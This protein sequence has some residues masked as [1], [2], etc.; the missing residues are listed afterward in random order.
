MNAPR[1]PSRSAS[2]PPSTLIA[3]NARPVRRTGP[4]ALQQEQQR[5]AVRATDG[6]RRGPVT[7]GRQHSALHRCFFVDAVAPSLRSA[8]RRRARCSSP[9]GASRRGF[10]RSRLAK[11]AVSAACCVAW[12]RTLSE[13]VA[14][15]RAASVPTPL[16]RHLG[17]WAR[18]AR[19]HVQRTGP[20]RSEGH[21]LLRLT[22]DASPRIEREGVRE[23][24]VGGTSRELVDEVGPIALTWP[25]RGALRDP[26]QPAT[27]CFVSV[28]NLAGE[29]T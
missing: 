21:L 24:S 5:L 15:R 10:R 22:A 12:R 6:R 27:E 8:V 29:P 7:H 18:Q 16:E 2:R 3:D 23:A 20:H 14:P 11:A 9:A 25:S 17:S 1:L 28:T 26:T 4:V 13:A 19:G